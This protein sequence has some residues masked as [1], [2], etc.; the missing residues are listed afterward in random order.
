[1]NAFS[2]METRGR[3][4]FAVLGF[5][6]LNACAPSGNGNADLGLPDETVAED[7]VSAQDAAAAADAIAQLGFQE[8][9]VSAMEAMQL[10]ATYAHVD[11]LDAI[12]AGLKAK[13]LAY[14]HANASRIKNKNYLT[15]VDFSA[16]A[17]TGRMHIINMTT[18]A[19]TSLHMAHARNSDPSNSGYATSFSNANGSNK[20]SLG[21]YL[22]AETYNGKHGLSLRLDGLSS[23]NSNVRARAIVIH[24]ATYVVDANVKAGRSLGCL[25]VSMQKRDSVVSMLKGGSLIYADTSK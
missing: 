11:M 2:R 17:S 14:Y 24:G 16:H 3:F 9:Q 25:A 10:K 21:Y 18:G 7:P 8:P 20:S 4:A 1:M 19:V 12:P 15:V 22:T 13:A 23:T 5:M 6:F